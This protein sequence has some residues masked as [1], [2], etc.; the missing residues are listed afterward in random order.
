[1]ASRPPRPNILLISFD[2]AV[3]FWKYRDVFGEEL[4]TPNLDRICERST[5]FQAAYCQSPVCGPSRTSF[6]SG[7]SPQQSQIFENKTRFFDKIE[8]STMWPHKLKDAGYFCSAGGKVHHGRGF[9]EE[10]SE[11]LYSDRPKQFGGLGGMPP[12]QPHVR[13]GGWRKGFALTDEKDFD[14]LYDTQA[15]TSAINFLQSYDAEEP[16][17]REIGFHSPHGPFVTPLPHKKAYDHRKFKKPAA[18]G[19]AYDP[20]LYEKG[21]ENEAFDP[22][23]QGAS[24]W[25]KSVRNYYSAYT[26]VDEQLGRVWDALK[27]SRHADN[28]I[29]VILSDH[30]FHLGERNRFGKTTLWEQVANVPLIVHD[31]SIKDAAVVNDPVPLLDVGQTLLDYAGLSPLE[32]CA[33]SSLRPYLEGARTPERA[34]PTFHYNNVAVRKGQYR[35]I[36]YAGGETQFYDLNQDPWQY[37]SL[38]SDHPAFQDVYAALLKASEEYGLTLDETAPTGT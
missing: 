38:G 27:A 1:V 28:T 34:V 20:C 33:G 8:P 26:Y 3:A 14:A 13:T 25:G 9:P 24:F 11:A 17:Y 35:L 2:D 16:F 37:K 5:A 21:K 19:E 36:R 10:V 4:K 23:K 12:K 18:W 31:P 7:Q 6:M 15:A 22:E 29:V 32:N 30:G